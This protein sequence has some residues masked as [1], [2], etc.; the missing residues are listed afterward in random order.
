VWLLHLKGLGETRIRHELEAVLGPAALPCS[1]A[2][3]TCRSGIS[4]LAD[5]ETPHGEMDDVIVQALGDFP[6]ASVI[7]AARKL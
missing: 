1:T 6:I 2:T 4:T 5:S 3:R 7:E